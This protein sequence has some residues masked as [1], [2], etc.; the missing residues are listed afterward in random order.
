MSSSS[1]S[2]RINNHDRTLLTHCRHHDPHSVYGWHP[3]D[4][5][6]AVLRTRQIGAKKVELVTKCGK[7]REMEPLGDDIFGLYI[8]KGGSGGGYG[9][10]M[11][12]A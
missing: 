3:L 4:N 8:K 6:D 1:E 10:R 12:F 7:T 5:G 11:V 9:L 2:L